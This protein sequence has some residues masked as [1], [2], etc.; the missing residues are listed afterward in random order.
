MCLKVFCTLLQQSEVMSRHIVSSFIYFNFRNLYFMFK[1]FQYTETK[2]SPSISRGPWK[3]EKVC[4]IFA[5]HIDTQVTRDKPLDSNSK[6]HFSSRTNINDNFVYE[7]QY[8]QGLTK[9][10]INLE[11]LHKSRGITAQEN[12]TVWM[13]VLQKEQDQVRQGK[14][15]MDIKSF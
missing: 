11:E 13:H 6:L 3:V 7:M 12:K 1:G 8:T 14:H 2:W 15:K 10:V 5:V 4:A 9:L